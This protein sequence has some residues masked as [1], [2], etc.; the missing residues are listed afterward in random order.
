MY[1]WMG[2]VRSSFGGRLLDNLASVHDGDG[3]GD[4][5]DE[6][7]VVRTRTTMA[8]PSSCLQLV[9]QVDNLLLDGHVQG[10]GGLVGR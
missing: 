3:V 2:L 9:E 5:G 7:Q 6:R 1:S 8:K 4:L 10:G